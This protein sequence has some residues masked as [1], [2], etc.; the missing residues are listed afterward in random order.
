MPFYHSLPQIGIVHEC[1]VSYICFRC[2]LPSEK[3]VV[4][5]FIGPMVAII[6]VSRKYL[7]LKHV[8]NAIKHTRFV[9]VSC[10][11][12]FLTSCI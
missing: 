12:I 3:G 1:F 8:S 10:V 9:S 2:W 5:A 7:I 6:L 11:Y 4:F